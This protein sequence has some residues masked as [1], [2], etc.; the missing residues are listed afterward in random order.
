MLQ[1]ISNVICL[2]ESSLKVKM[3]IAV[4]DAV[5]KESLKRSRKVPYI[6]NDKISVRSSTQMVEH[7]TSIP[8]VKG[9]NPV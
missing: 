9:S 1:D 8:E 7:Y 4:V 3:I 5:A 2:T 6:S